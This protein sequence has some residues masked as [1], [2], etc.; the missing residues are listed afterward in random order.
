MKSANSSKRIFC[1]SI[2]GSYNYMFLE[3]KDAELQSFL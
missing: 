1:F 2:K 3:R